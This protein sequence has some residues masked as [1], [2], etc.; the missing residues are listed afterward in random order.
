LYIAQLAPLIRKKTETDK[1]RKLS[2]NS[3]SIREIAMISL[4][5][6]RKK[7]EGNIIEEW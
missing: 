1:L 5:E 2:T 6:K 4:R 7:G 3:Y